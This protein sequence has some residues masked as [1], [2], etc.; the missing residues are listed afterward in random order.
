[1]TGG[2]MGT[3]VAISP[4]GSKLAFTARD[5][6]GHTRLW[7]RAIDRIDAQ[8]VGGTDEAAF[9]FW[10]PDS[11]FIG[12]FAGKGLIK[13]DV[14]SGSTQTVCELIGTSRGG[15]WNRDDVIVFG[16]VNGALYRV[17]AAG[18]DPK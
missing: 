7:L 16:V 15:A 17:S 6:K 10:S 12:F 9:P 11:R 13:V 3:S 8:E 18:G 1:V 14:N 5:P 2:R 4:D